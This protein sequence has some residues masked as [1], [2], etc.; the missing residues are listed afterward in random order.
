VD[1]SFTKVADGNLKNLTA[2][3][4]LHTLKLEGTRVTDAG[5]KNLAPLK[6]LKELGLVDTAVTLEAIDEFQKAHPGLLVELRPI[7]RREE[8]KGQN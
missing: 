3:P 1:L 4:Q 5:L 2:L 8:V 6:E 7:I